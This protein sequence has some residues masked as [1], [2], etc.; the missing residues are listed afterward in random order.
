MSC[1]QEIAA[2]VLKDADGALHALVSSV[3]PN[4]TV[5]SPEKL[6]MLLD[7]LR[8]IC[9]EK[10]R[11]QP[12]RRCRSL[13][14]ARLYVADVM[15]VVPR[16]ICCTMSIAG[17]ISVQSFSTYM[18]NTVCMQGCPEDALQALHTAGHF[19]QQATSIAR[20][21]DVRLFIGPAIALAVQ[22]ISLELSQQILPP[23]MGLAAPV[24]EQRQEVQGKQP[25]KRALFPEPQAHAGVNGSPHQ[26]DLAAIWHGRAHSEIS[27]H[28]SSS[29]ATQ[30]AA[31][32]RALPLPQASQ[33]LAGPSNGSA[34]QLAVPLSHSSVLL[35]HLQK[36][37]PAP[38]QLPGAQQ[39][40]SGAASP[41]ASARL[42]S[43]P[44]SSS[45]EASHSSSGSGQAGATQHS[46]GMAVAA[47]ESP[48]ASAL[49]EAYRGCRKHLKQLQAGHLAALLRFWLQ[50]GPS[51]IPSVASSRPELR[52][53]LRLR[54]LQDGIAASRRHAGK[55][56]QPAEVSHTPALHPLSTRVTTHLSTQ[57]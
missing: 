47:G 2:E 3:W 29:N 49:E 7:M 50:R 9:T 4:I 53:A 51:P 52:G 38:Q 5:H 6:Q 21:L 22:H 17:Y 32:M 23:L 20:G 11:S 40:P 16:L 30:L 25:L 28:I 43:Q 13:V 34:V 36:A 12:I 19:A 54:A 56:R 31:L 33:A 45:A 1:A 37:L 39:Q 14:I 46:L 8:R 57:N 42:E 24:L 18:V 44:H 26:A 27:Q 10:A 41:A 55:A 35:V 48:E 15:H